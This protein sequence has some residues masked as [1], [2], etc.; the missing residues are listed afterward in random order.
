MPTQFLTFT[1][2]QTYRIRWSWHCTLPRQHRTSHTSWDVQWS[3]RTHDQSHEFSHPVPTQEAR[4]VCIILSKTY[5]SHNPLPYVRFQMDSYIICESVQAL[6]FLITA[7]LA[8]LRSMRKLAILNQNLIPYSAKF[9]RH[10]Y[11]VDWPLK[12]ISLH[13]VRGMTAYRKPR[14]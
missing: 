6:S 7:G 14:L 4:M 2:T 1:C 12:A 13:N 5:R 8:H 9:S 10:L 11:F 3:P